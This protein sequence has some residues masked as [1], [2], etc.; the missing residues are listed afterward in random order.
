M[1]DKNICVTHQKRFQVAKLNKVDHTTEHKCKPL[2]LLANLCPYSHLWLWALGIDQK[3][4]IAD[5]N[6]GNKLYVKDGWALP[7]R[8]SSVIGECFRYLTKMPPGQVV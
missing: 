4:E 3:N 8:R 5:A 1:Q 7:Y 6:G 2:D